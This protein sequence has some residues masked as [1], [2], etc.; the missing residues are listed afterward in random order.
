MT[1]V[2][3]LLGAPSVETDG[4]PTTPARGRKS[5]ALLSLLVLSERPPTR[6]RLATLLF[7]DADDPL[8][9][10]RW[11]LADLRRSLAALRR[12]RRRPGRS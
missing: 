11:S 5:W 9:A 1:V 2:V 3:R 4:A 12:D 10:L 8:G 7:P 6:Q